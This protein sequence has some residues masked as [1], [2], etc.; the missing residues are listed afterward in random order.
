MAVL[1]RR[2]ESARLEPGQDLH[3]AAG[4]L[5][6][7]RPPVCPDADL[8]LLDADAELGGRL[9]PFVEISHEIVDGQG[10]GGAKAS[11]CRA[12]GSKLMEWVPERH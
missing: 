5:V 4:P 1:T 12:E 8:L 11:R 10:H 9:G 6:G 7:H 3:A 2:R